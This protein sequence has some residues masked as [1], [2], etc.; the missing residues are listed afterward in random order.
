[1]DGKLMTVFAEPRTTLG[2]EFLAVWRSSFNTKLQ[3]NHKLSDI[4]IFTCL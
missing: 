3:A 1:L 2:R 4:F